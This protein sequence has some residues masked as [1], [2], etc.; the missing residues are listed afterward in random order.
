MQIQMIPVADGVSLAVEAALASGKPTIVLSS[1]VGAGLGMWDELAAR[2]SG[3]FSIVRYDARGHGQSQITDE[4]ITLATLG[5][6]VIRILDALG[7]SRATICGL[8]L[9]GLT[10]QWLGVHHAGRFNGIVLANTAANFPPAAMWH[11]RA[12]A[13]RENGMQPLVAPTVDRWFTRA[14]QEREPKRVAEIAEMFSKTSSVG[15]ARCCEVLASADMLPELK[16]IRLPAC[17]LCG[18]HDPSTPP[19]RGEE[20]AAEIPNAGIV[21]LKAAHISAI[22]DA[23]GFAD[24]VRIFCAKLPR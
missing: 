1:S 9:G 19:A 3:D 13:V 10:A 14:F 6:D 8:S 21:T 20:L 7:V 22:E 12:R 16:S 23:D 15:Y 5:G 17:I 24:A 11:D 4:P 18:E 2:L